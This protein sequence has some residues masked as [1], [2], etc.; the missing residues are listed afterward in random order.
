[1]YQRPIN[2]IRISN[3]YT[4]S[5]PVYPKTFDPYEAADINRDNGGKG[6]IPTNSN[7]FF[8]ETLDKAFEYL[9]SIEKNVPV[10]NY[11][12]GNNNPV[13]IG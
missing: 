8:F 3:G 1:M 9:K 6:Y 4:V 2:I 5:V 13:M 7:I 11:A 10:D 12:F